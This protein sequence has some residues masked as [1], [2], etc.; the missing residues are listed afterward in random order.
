MKT[1]F[2]VI[3]NDNLVIL[4]GQLAEVVS[5]TGGWT[6][7]DTES[8]EQIKVRNGAIRRVTEDDLKSVKVNKM[9]QEQTA[10]QRTPRE[11]IPAHVIGSGEK[12][13]KIG[14]VE[15]DMSGY[16]VSERKANGRRSIDC[17]DDV[18][19]QL[20]DATIE[21]IYEMAAVETETSVDDLKSKYGRLNIGMQRMNLGNI[22]R[23]AEKARLAK[24]AK[25]EA[26]IE[27]EAKARIRAEE[28][29][30]A[31]IAKEQAKAAKLAEKEA[32]KAAKEAE[33]DA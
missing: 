4:A 32:A 9:N 25:E 26:K 6:T 2:N 18:A 5:T 30:S 1:R 28:K 13:G 19:A 27:R 17:N 3:N 20:R 33:D 16:Y 21:E 29:E 10:A 7:V 15:F 11:V 12:K 31:R 22:I 23:G 24:A 8:G 14:N